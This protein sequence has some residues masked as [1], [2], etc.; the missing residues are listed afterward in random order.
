M[1][2]TRGSDSPKNDRIEI[3]FASPTKCN[4]TATGLF[5]IER[6]NVTFFQRVRV[7]FKFVSRSKEDQSIK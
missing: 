6:D 5:E 1:F 3:R 2:G 4:D 7:T